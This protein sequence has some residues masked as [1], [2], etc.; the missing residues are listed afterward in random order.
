MVKNVSRLSTLALVILLLTSA[1]YL[2]AEPSRE[3]YLSA[4]EL[5]DLY[6]S[7]YSSIHNV[8]FLYN[9]VLEKTEGNLSR[10]NRFI[11]TH[12]VERIEEGN[13][14]H[15]R[16]SSKPDGF[17]SYRYAPQCAFDGLATSE[18][19]PDRKAGI[20]VGGKTGRAPEVMNSL[21]HYMLINKVTAK[22]GD[23]GGTP[24]I[25]VTIT[26]TSTVRPKLEQ[27][28]G[29]WCHVVDTT[30]GKK[31]KPYATVWFAADKGGLPI[32]YEKY[33]WWE[34]NGQGKCSRRKLVTKVGSVDTDGCTI[35][36][37]EQ[38]TKEVNDKDGYRLYRFQVQS[39]RA[40][41]ETTADTFK[42][43]FPP[44]TDI[45]DHV[46]GIYYTTG[47]FDEK[48]RFGVLEDLEQKSEEYTPPEKKVSPATQESLISTTANKPPDTS[49]AGKELA[50][51][52]PKTN[53]DQPRVN[54]PLVKTVLTVIAILAACIIALLVYRKRTK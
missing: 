30:I 43:S 34:K 42:V 39:L 26:P 38:A 4:E 49:D 8:H 50:V 52:S 6:E 1:S 5:L 9:T 17:A 3:S 19:F 20:I 31:S 25:R 54:T 21:W 7:M 28:S 37:P 51:T 10:L 35:W 22:E 46:A 29:Q 16:H 44:G 27:V 12:T 41:I 14:Y 11:R 2:A 15:V 23:P 45:V 53:L 32:K 18:Y 48:K 24:F 36:Y 40:N 13:K 47:A 33:K